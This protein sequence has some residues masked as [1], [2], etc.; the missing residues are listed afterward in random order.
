M[1]LSVASL[2]YDLPT[3]VSHTVEATSVHHQAWLVS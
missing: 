2:D 1:F 3:Y